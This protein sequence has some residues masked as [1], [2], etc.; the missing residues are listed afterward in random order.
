MLLTVMQ[1]ELQENKDSETLRSIL[2]GY[3]QLILKY[4]QR[5]YSRQLVQ[6]ENGESDIL[7]RFHRLLIEYFS[8]GKQ[9]ENGVPT[10]AYCAS[11]LAYSAR[12]F[13][14]LVHA[15]TGGTAIGYIHNFLIGE[16]KNLLIKGLPVSDVADILGF[17]YSHHFSRLFK[18]M[19]GQTPTE[20]IKD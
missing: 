14:D 6:K 20:F 9:Y 1:K 17:R 13:G 8:K 4:C 19:T 10:V 18:K 15:A 12:Y 7:K 11:E 3:L 2:I 16:A 5:I